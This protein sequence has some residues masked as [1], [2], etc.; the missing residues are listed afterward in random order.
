M[1]FFESLLLLLLAAVALLQVSS[2]LRLPYPAMLAAAGVAVAFIPGAPEIR[3][4]PQTVLALFIAPVL[5][6]A[7]YDFPLTAA[8]ALWRPLLVLAVGAVLTTAAAVAWIGWWAAGLPLAAAVVL[9]AI[10]A[11]P[12]AAATVAVLGSISLPRRTVDVLR[13]ESLFN[14]AVA[15]LLFDAA[16]TVQSL[17]RLDGAA[18]VRLTLAAPG[19]LL[20]GVTFGWLMMRLGRFVGDSLGGTLLQFLNTF[21]VWLVAERLHV[22]A[23]LAVVACAMTLARFSRTTASPRMRVHAF[24]V[25]ASVVFVLNVLAF[26]LMGMQARLIIEHMPTQRLREA[27]LVSG[28]V[29]L[30]LVVTRF[31]VVMGWNRLAARFAGVRGGLP[32]PSLGQGV[33]VSWSGMRGLVTL[34]AALS[35]PA[36]FP[37]RDLVV[38]TAFAAV[39]ATL[40]LQGLTLPPLI[41]ILGLDRREQAAH[42][43]SQARR[44]LIQAG[45]ARMDVHGDAADLTMRAVQGLE[46]ETETGAPGAASQVDA[47][48]KLGL[49]SLEDQRRA[50]QGLRDNQ[51]IDS[52]SFYLL[53]EELDWRELTYLPEAQRKIDQV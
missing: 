28:L 31:A 44:T 14:D 51:K 18:A 13:G 20:L 8:G 21:L 9:G 19:G 41:R 1:T 23:V 17:G 25:W 16:L 10:V 42:D 50:L 24:S 4:D 34:A 45:L 15:L 2:R 32:A 37:Q 33:V 22:S 38:L 46:L 40:V 5:L 3:L 11:P 53:Q 36:S 12:D 47:Y 43:L 6:D 52:D 48:R 49:E 30:A 35:L 26:L 27:A 7:A 29:I 39:L